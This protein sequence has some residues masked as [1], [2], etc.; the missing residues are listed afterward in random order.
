M[1]FNPNVRLSFTKQARWPLKLIEPM[2][3]DEFNLA[4]FSILNKLR[5]YALRSDRLDCRFEY[6]MRQPF[7]HQF[8]LLN[9]AVGQL[10]CLVQKSFYKNIE[11]KMLQH[12]CKASTIEKTIMHRTKWI[13]FP[14]MW[15]VCMLLQSSMIIFM[16]SN[17]VN[18]DQI[19]SSFVYEFM[20]LHKQFEWQMEIWQGLRMQLNDDYSK[21]MCHW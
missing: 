2:K 3:E 6:A 8:C 20:G 17:Y 12:F 15:P 16:L 11:I 21:W 18:V 1:I 4:L 14:T 13:I 10:C 7:V 5:E 19:R 9:F